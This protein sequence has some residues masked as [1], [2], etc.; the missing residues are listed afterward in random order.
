MNYYVAFT[1]IADKKEVIALWKETL[2]HYLPRYVDYRAET[3]ARFLFTSKLQFP[4]IS[5]EGRDHGIEW[6]SPR[7]HQAMHYYVVDFGVTQLPWLY[8]AWFWLAGS[9]LIG[10]ALIRRWHRHIA[11]LSLVSS[12]W[13]YLMSYIPVVP[14]QDYRYSYWPALAVTLTVLVLLARNWRGILLRFGLI[15]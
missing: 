4:G 5:D 14:A 7:L 13:I 9:T 12:G 3:F 11:E 6:D 8:H 15:S 10:L 1:E 2:P